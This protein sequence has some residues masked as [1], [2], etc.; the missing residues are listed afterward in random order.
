MRLDLDRFRVGFSGD[1]GAVPMSATVREGF[2][3]AMQKLES[4]FS[5]V[6]PASPDCSG[7]TESFAVLGAAIQFRQH[8]FVKLHRDELTQSFI[9]N[10]ERGEG[11]T[12]DN[13]LRAEEA[14]TRVFRNFIRYFERY[15]V[16]LT[17]S[18]SVPPFPNSQEDVLDVDGRPLSSIIDYLGITYLISLVGFPCLSIPFRET[19]FDTPIGIQIVVP[20]YQEARAIAFAKHLESQLGFAHTWPQAL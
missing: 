19:P 12:A 5:V 18:A 13:F 3:G 10:V 6:E 11:L 14:R 20:P 2:A 4:E 15:D 17:P 7:A 9:W 1:L 16:L 8:D